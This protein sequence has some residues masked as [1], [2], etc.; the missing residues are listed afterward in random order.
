MPKETNKT[1]ALVALLNSNSVRAAAKD[2]GLSEDTLYRYI[3]EDEDFKKQLSDAR[4]KYFEQSISRL[5]RLTE[6]ASE[7]LERNLNCEQP[8]VETRT[9][10]VIYD[11]ANKGIET[12]DILAR[13]E[14]LENANQ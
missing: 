13:L 14:A 9:A 10:Q 1:K 4:R 6:T 2:C 11:H 3:R 7:T 5:I 8:A 12:L